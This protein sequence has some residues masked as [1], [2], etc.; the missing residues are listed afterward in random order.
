MKYLMGAWVIL[1]S[2]SMFYLVYLNWES[3]AKWATESKYIFIVMGIWTIYVYF[4]KTEKRGKK[5]GK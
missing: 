1:L 3:K 2:L 4:F 5:E